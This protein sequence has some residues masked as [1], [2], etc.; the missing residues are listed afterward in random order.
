MAYRDGFGFLDI[1]E[2]REH[3]RVKE[4][5]QVLLS[6]AVAREEAVVIVAVFG[7]VDPDKVA[8]T[9]VLKHGFD[10]DFALLQR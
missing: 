2:R 10:Q 4:L 8:T 3:F 7:W 9:L 1:F 6:L 5:V